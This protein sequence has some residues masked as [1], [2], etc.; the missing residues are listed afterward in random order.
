ME[1]KSAN[2]QAVDKLR[3]VSQRSTSPR[4][5]MRFEVELCGEFIFCSTCK[6]T[7]FILAPDEDNG[8]EKNFIEECPDCN[9]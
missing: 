6:A 4:E 7:G 2:D 5:I 8:T 9:S 3:I 1:A